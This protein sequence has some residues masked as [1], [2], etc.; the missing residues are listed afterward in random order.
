MNQPACNVRLAILCISALAGLCAI[1]GAFLCWKG[2]TG[3]DVLINVATGAVGGL[4]GM[5]STR[6]S[7]L[8]PP[9]GTTA[10]VSTATTQTPKP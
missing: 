8:P 1:L 2:Y 7:P 9:D 4:V 5:I 3:G 6:N 10:T